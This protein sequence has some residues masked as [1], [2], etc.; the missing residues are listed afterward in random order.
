MTSIEEVPPLIP[1][2]IY[3]ARV[4][5]FEIQETRIGVNRFF[6]IVLLTFQQYKISHHFFGNLDTLNLILENKDHFINQE[7]QIKVRHIGNND[8]TYYATQRIKS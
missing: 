6:L 4:S 8:K 3:T 1:A 7:W 2:G 5:G